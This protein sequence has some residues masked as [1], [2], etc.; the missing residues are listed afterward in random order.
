MLQKPGKRFHG[1]SI[2]FHAS[3]LF[4]N[5]CKCWGASYLTLSWEMEIKHWFGMGQST[6]KLI[7]SPYVK[8]LAVR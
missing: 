6:V 2:P 1:I 5:P 3:V 4:P 8:S 7:S